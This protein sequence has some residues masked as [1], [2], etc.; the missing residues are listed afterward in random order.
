MK[1]WLRTTL[2][3]YVTTSYVLVEFIFPSYA[4]TRCKGSESTLLLL[5]NSVRTLARQPSGDVPGTMIV[6]APSSIKSLMAALIAPITIGTY[7][8]ISSISFPCS[9][10]LR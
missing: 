9:S 8:L 3:F 5:S 2:Y 4:T 7:D 1:P 10:P 6:F